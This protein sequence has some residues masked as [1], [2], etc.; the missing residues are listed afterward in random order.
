VSCLQVL[1]IASLPKRA[2][3]SY[4]EGLLLCLVLLEGDDGLVGKEMG[5]L[6]VFG[7]WDVLMIALANHTAQLMMWAMQ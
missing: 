4:E 7:Y 5:N 6:P 1:A 2:A 3:T